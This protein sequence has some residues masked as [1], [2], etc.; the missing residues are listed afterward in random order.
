V[1]GGSSG[2]PRGEGP[3][4]P[5]GG[6]RGGPAPITH[7]Q[8]FTRPEIQPLYVSEGARHPLPPVLPLDQT[9]PV[10]GFSE[11]AGDS[12][13]LI[14]LIYRDADAPELMVS[15]P[16]ARQTPPAVPSAPVVAAPRAEPTAPVTAADPAPTETAAAPEPTEDGSAYLAAAVLAPAA[17]WLSRG[18][19]GA[20]IRTAFRILRIPHRQPTQGTT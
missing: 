6:P 2:G 10:A 20:L 13:A 4:G 14:Y 19:I 17:A 15:A 9:L 11:S 12:L 1:F 5:E 3:G 16:V 8:P 18:Y 7:H